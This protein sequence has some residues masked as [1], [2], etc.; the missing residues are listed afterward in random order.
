MWYRVH[1]TNL[2][3]DLNDVFNKFIFISELR[4]NDLQS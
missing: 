3:I 2:I 1:D 4:T